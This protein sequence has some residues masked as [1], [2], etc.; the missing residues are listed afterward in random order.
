MSVSETFRAF[1]ELEV[2]GCS[3]TTVA[4]MTPY[5]ALPILRVRG[6]DIVLAIYTE[7]E[8]GSG[9]D[10]QLE[11]TMEFFE[12]ERAEGRAV[13][14]SEVSPAKPNHCICIARD[15]RDSYAYEPIRHAIVY[16]D[17]KAD[18][19]RT[20]ADGLYG[21]DDAV[22]REHMLMLYH[23]VATITGDVDDY[24]RL[25]LVTE[26]ED[27]RAKLTAKIIELTLERVKAEIKAGKLRSGVMAKNLQTFR[28]Q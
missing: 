3:D 8:D 7:R 12:Q 1:E 18:G 21:C 2:I 6:T 16:L 20:Q 13:G 22:D 23:N 17:M 11:T 9:V 25:L 19:S 15:A 26:D 4:S 5:M 27:A 28:V 10:V 14:F 24:A